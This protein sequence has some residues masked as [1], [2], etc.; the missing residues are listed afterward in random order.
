MSS[1]SQSSVRNRILA[2]LSAD[3]FAL[4]EPHLEPVPLTFRSTVIPAGAPIQ[5]VFFVERGL[6]SLIAQNDD[7]RI[8]VGM[9][10]PEGLVGVNALLGTD[11]SPISSLVQADGEALRMATDWLHAAVGESATLHVCL[12]RYVQFLMIQTAQTAYANANFDVEARLARWVLMTQDRLGRADLPLTHEFLSLMLGTRR[13]SVT[14]ALHVLEGNGLIRATRGI[15]NVRD[16]D[17][18]MEL[19]DDS[20]GLAEAEYERLF[21]RR[22]SV[23]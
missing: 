6:V 18:L 22:P 20:Y 9:V 8:E 2:S 11:T 5:D 4:L 17:K 10:G 3:D 7:A 13:S 16:R 15:I 12:L 21:G 19:A 23:H 14:T 1:L